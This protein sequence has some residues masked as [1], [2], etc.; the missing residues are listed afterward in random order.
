MNSIYALLISPVTGILTGRNGAWGLLGLHLGQTLGEARLALNGLHVVFVES[1][2]VGLP[3]TW[4]FF[5]ADETLPP[6]LN[7]FAHLRLT[8]DDAGRLASILALLLGNDGLG[9]GINADSPPG[10]AAAALWECARSALFQVNPPTRLTFDG[11]DGGIAAQTTD[12]GKV[13][14]DQRLMDYGFAAFHQTF[15]C[16]LVPAQVLDTGGAEVKTLETFSTVAEYEAAVN[17]R[18]KA[19]AEQGGSHAS[20]S[21]GMAQSGDFVRPTIMVTLA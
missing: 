9:K 17:A 3:N 14:W 18:R 21:I 6:E 1:K 19:V 2:V 8:F 4:D 20:I 11:I 16:Q 10:E 7:T 13:A 12:A 5:A 15:A